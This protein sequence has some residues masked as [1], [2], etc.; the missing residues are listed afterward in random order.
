MYAVIASGGKQY[1]VAQGEILQVEMLTAEV[2]ASVEFPVLMVTNGDKIEVGAPYLTG[3]KVSGSVVEHGRGDKV[4]IVK[5][6]RRKHSRKQMG[7]RQ[8]F[9]A[10]K[11]ENISA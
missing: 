4:K 10:V 9:T 5:M 6:R 7:H 8:W 2:G 3:V 11:I 1:K